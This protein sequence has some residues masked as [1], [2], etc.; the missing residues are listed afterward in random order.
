MTTITSLKDDVVVKAKEITGK[1]E[2]S[3]THASDV[4]VY[5]ST[6]W[7]YELSTT[8]GSICVSNITHFVPILVKNISEPSDSVAMYLHALDKVS[9]IYHDFRSN[10]SRDS[11]RDDRSRYDSSSN[12]SRVLIVVITTSYSC[13]TTCIV[14][15]FNINSSNLIYKLKS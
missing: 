10:D 15:S 1:E 6:Q 9:H 4:V 12:D 13:I 7:C 2:E 14:Q 5:R 11:S 3:R 8:I